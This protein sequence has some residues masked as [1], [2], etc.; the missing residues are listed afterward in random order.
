MELA[1]LLRKLLQFAEI[2]PG[3]VKF[4]HRNKYVFLGGGLVVA[5][6]ASENSSGVSGEAIRVALGSVS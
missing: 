2:E 4:S 3:R 1:G 6:L 5:F